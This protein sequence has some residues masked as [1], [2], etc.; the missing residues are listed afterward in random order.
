MG[1]SASVLA[2]TFA[3][4]AAPSVPL[5]VATAASAVVC[6]ASAVAAADCLSSDFTHFT[7]TAVGFAS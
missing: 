5:P 1:T 4:S 7:G 3:G 6:C 2:S